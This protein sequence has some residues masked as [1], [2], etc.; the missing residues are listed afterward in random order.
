MV[1]CHLSRKAA[2]RARKGDDSTKP[3]Q[4]V[5]T[6]ITQKVPEPCHTV[7]RAFHVDSDEADIYR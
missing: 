5:G 1:N 7:R 4:E 3:G 2:Y 6:N